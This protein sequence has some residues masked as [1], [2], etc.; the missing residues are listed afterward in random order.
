MGITLAN[1]AAIY[2]RVST[3]YQIDKDS[4]KVQ[5]REL[6]AYCQMVLGIQD[7]V[8]FKDAGYSAK[9]TDRPD[10]Q[11]MMERLRS[12]EFSHL[13]VWKID[14]ISRNVLDFASM[15]KE[16]KSLGIAF[17]SKNEQFDT[18]NAMG[19]AMLKIILVF[20]ELE[21]NITSER[22]TAVMLSRANS[23]QW[24]GGW[25]PFGYDWDKSTKT[26][27]INQIQAKVVRM[28]Y[29]LYEQYQSCIFVS[30]KL[31][32]DGYVTKTGKNWSSS[33][34]HCVL[35]NPFYTGTYRYNRQ[36]H[37]GVAQSND[38]SE[39]IVIHDHHDAII[40]EAQFERVNI[41]LQRNIRGGYK[42]GEVHLRKNVILFSGLLKCGL[43]GAT[44]GGTRDRPRK[45]GYRPAVYGC[46]K[47]R[48]TNACTNKHI[49]DLKIGPFVF[50]FIA[51]ILK[52]SKSKKHFSI[53]ALESELL[54]GSCF[55]DIESIDR[56]SLSQFCDL[57]SNQTDKVSYVP[58][59]L[60]RSQSS[61]KA[62]VLSIL[63][64]RK[65]KAE[66][67][68]L[69]L[70]RLYLYGDAELA[71]KDYAIERKKLID[72][73]QECEKEI[74][75]NSP[76]LQGFTDW[77]SETEDIKLKS[78][79]YILVDQLL[80]NKQFD[81]EKY[82]TVIDQTVMRNFLLGI[83]ETIEISDQKIDSIRLKN[84]ILFI[85]NRSMDNKEKD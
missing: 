73:I 50:S 24:N 84:G 7:Y 77:V 85:F 5:E 32:E 45:N 28:I 51:N 29:D 72:E 38:E 3:M 61:D 9:N 12:G 43:C 80:K 62:S 20:A 18:S 58:H 14:R 59:F 25:V 33:T 78:S 2:I 44:M 39:W 26:L 30:R 36:K 10:Y 81:F 15:Y 76:I 41:A 68:L 65:V 53:N 67:A 19:E 34:I 56:K 23:G 54:K 75:A 22:T 83:I 66:N 55:D 31:N 46:Q 64:D 71:E 49:N 42:R 47:R 13:L 17:V 37:L 82:V 21:R 74:T 4:L 6:I 16:L 63:K 79:Y 70:K 35:T 8:V 40:S 1:K 48:A 69:R 57:L 11:K 27:D 60:S 52:I